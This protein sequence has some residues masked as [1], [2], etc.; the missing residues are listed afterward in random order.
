MMAPPR[1][2]LA[3]LALAATFAAGHAS[4]ETR[5]VE[6]G[7]LM[8][9][10]TLSSHITIDTDSSLHGA[11]R[12]SADSSLSCVQ[13]ESGGPAQISTAGCSDDMDSLRITVPPSMAVTLTGSGSG[14]ARIGDLR[15]TLVATLTSS[16]DI[17]VGHVGRLTLSSNSSGD[18]VVGRVEGPAELTTTASGDVRIGYIGGDLAISHHGSG[19]MAIGAIEASRASIDS[20]GSG[21]MLIGAG[22][23]GTLQAHIVGS[24]DLAVAATVGGGDVEAVGGADVKL[25]SV[26]GEVHRSSSGG[27]DISVGGS[28]VVAD[29]TGRVARLVSQM[30]SGGTSHTVSVSG[31][32][33]F[34]HVLTFALLVLMA[35]IGWRIVRRGGGLAGL[36][37]RGTPAAPDAPVHPGVQAVCDTLGRLEQ[38]LGR[39]EG[40]VTTREFDLNRKFRELGPR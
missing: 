13:V 37:R 6:G 16:Y 33:V 8:L 11:V 26:T 15:G 9:T 3:G 7:S 34:H 28:A 14:S 20:A 24:G 23:I 1:L 32:H 25:A 12:L 19:D 27:S 17:K 4:A 29:V 30:P 38:R 31:G 35:F 2:R 22:H 10:D 36:R 39:M 40:Y 21:D 18:S 5:T